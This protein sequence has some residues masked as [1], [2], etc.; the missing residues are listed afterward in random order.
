MVFVATPLLCPFTIVSHIFTLKNDI[1]KTHFNNARF[2]VL[3]NAPLTIYQATFVGHWLIMG[4]KIDSSPI[5]AQLSKME[6]AIEN[7][8]SLAAA[9]NLVINQLM[10]REATLAITTKAAST[11]EPKWTTMMAKNVR[12]VVSR[13]VETL[14]DVPKEE[15]G[16][17]QV[18]PAS[19]GL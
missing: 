5:N 16:G 10:E 8:A 14:V 11:E 7:I 3:G 19:Y 9:S 1:A 13:A 2:N 4:L 18:Q 15:T 6:A 17:A 12:Q